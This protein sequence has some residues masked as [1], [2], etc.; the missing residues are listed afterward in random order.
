[1]NIPLSALFVLG[2]E[3]TSRSDV[4]FV[5]DVVSENIS[6]PKMWLFL[7]VWM[8]AFL[9]CTI[10]QTIDPLQSLCQKLHLK[11]T[12]LPKK[13]RISTL[14]LSWTCMIICL[15][16]QR[17]C[18]IWMEAFF[19]SPG[20]HFKKKE[21][22]LCPTLGFLFPPKIQ[23]FVETSLS[24][25]NS[26]CQP[27]RTRVDLTFKSCWFWKKSWKS[28]V[29]SNLKPSVQQHPLLPLLRVKSLIHWNWIRSIYKYPMTQFLRQ[30]FKGKCPFLY[31][32]SFFF[33][34]FVHFDH[35]SF[36]SSCEWVCFLFFLTSEFLHVLVVVV[37]VVETHQIKKITQV[38][39]SE[40]LNWLPL[41]IFIFFF[42]FLIQ[43]ECAV[44]IH[45]L[46]SKRA[47]R[48]SMFTD[49]DKDPRT[50]KQKLFQSAQEWSSARSSQKLEMDI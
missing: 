7:P 36:A 3:S 33:F 42:L 15:A 45:P 4:T 27:K 32:L 50:E 6:R 49:T 5:Q 21:H 40:G 9:W 34:F 25:F 35:F 31:C 1:M 11:N 38:K 28:C 39:S 48:W 26:L 18:L 37:F 10:W 16:L 17:L 24:R 46:E 22:F 20:P 23:K 44:D 29:R 2:K 30:F 47:R 19:K 8:M 13:E 43:Y 14:R 41:W 12:P